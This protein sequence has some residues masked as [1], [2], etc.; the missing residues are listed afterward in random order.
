MACGGLAAATRDSAAPIVSLERRTTTLSIPKI[1]TPLFAFALRENSPF[2][3]CRL[4]L[5]FSLI[6]QNRAVNIASDAS[7]VPK[8]NNITRILKHISFCNYWRNGIKV[9]AN[10]EL[11]VGTRLLMSSDEVGCLLIGAWAS[12]LRGL[13]STDAMLIITP[14]EVPPDILVSE[15]LIKFSQEIN[16]NFRVYKCLSSFFQRNLI[17]KLLNTF[18]F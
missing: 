1:E 16:N 13:T 2:L 10:W 4:R 8:I 6:K 9:P 15:M 14:S 3:V 17:S 11:S 18:K 12:R 5:C 7:P